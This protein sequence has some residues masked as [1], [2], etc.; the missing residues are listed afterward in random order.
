MSDLSSDEREK[1]RKRNSTT[2]TTDPQS[3]YAPSLDCFSCISFCLCYHLLSNLF[4]API[5]MRAM[6]Q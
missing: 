2:I 5:T 6:L 4:L 3:S 1:K